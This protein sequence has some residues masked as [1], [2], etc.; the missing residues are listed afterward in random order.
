MRIKDNLDA[1]SYIES[2]DKMAAAINSAIIEHTGG[3]LEEV[4]EPMLAPNRR[5][6]LFATIDLYELP[7]FS[8]GKEVVS[9]SRDCGTNNVTVFYW[10]NKMKFDFVGNELNVGDEVVMMQIGYRNLVR[11]TITKM[12][13]KMCI[14]SHE[15]TNTGSTESKQYYNQLV[16][17][18]YR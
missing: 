9:V 18:C 8:E 4:P 12:M 10:G 6:L 16:L 1:Y 3:R 15:K 2:K 7:L 17:V 5:M 13:D 14:V 11:G